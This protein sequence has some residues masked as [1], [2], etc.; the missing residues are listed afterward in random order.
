MR[1]LKEQSFSQN[2]MSRQ[3][4]INEAMKGPLDQRAYSQTSV[5]LIPSIGLRYYGSTSLIRFLALHET[6]NLITSELGVG[7]DKNAWKSEEA[8][9]PLFKQVMSKAKSDA[10][11]W[12]GQIYFVFLPGTEILRDKLGRRQLRS[13]VLQVLSELNIPVIDLYPVFQQH[14]DP[15]S[16]F[17]LPNPHYNVAGYQLTAETIEKTLAE[18]APFTH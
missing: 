14:T 7:A 11:G 13:E 2:L 4:E 16:L 6:R 5:L 12:N 10:A 17:N 9:M 1:Y 18:K 3:Q 15:L 8:E